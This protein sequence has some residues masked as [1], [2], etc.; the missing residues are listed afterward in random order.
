MEIKTVE[1]VEAAGLSNPIE[2]VT[3][4]QMAYATV[5]DYGMKAGLAILVTSFV[6]YLM[7][8]VQP[9]V[10]VSDLPNYWSMPVSQYLKATGV[11]TGW[12]WVSLVKHGDFL[13][14]IGIAFLSAVTVVC[15]LRILPFQMKNKDVLLGSIVLIEVL[16]LALGASGVLSAGH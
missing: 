13:N 8:I 6:L 11:G 1:V 2:Y 9:L 3:P 7:G 12:S 10:P 16:V 15:Y 14:F 4:E 5:L